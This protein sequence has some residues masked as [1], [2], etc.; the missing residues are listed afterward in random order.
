MFNHMNFSEAVEVSV[1][2]NCFVETAYA[3]FGE[4]GAETLCDAL[5]CYFAHADWHDGSGYDL[6]FCRIVALAF[7]RNNGYQ[8][9]P[10]FSCLTNWAGYK[11]GV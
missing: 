9:C 2:A 3:L 7:E 10:E 1:S 6:D 5:H 11:R 8:P 4:A